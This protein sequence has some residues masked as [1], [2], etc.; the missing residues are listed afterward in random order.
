MIRVALPFGVGTPEEKRVNYRSALRG[1]GIE[2]VEEVSTLEGLD[3]LMLAGGI[4]VDPA[5]YGAERAPETEEPDTVRDALER[6]LI[7]QAL[8]RDLPIL[9]ICRGIQMFNVAL[10]GSL[11]QHVEGHRAP[12]QREAHPV[13]IEPGSV[14]ESILNRREFM[15]NS[16]HHQCVGTIAP[17]LAVTAKSPD[18]IVEALSGAGVEVLYDDR[19]ERAGVKFKDADLVGV[20]IRIAVGKKGLASG[21]AEWKLRASK[22]VE[23]VPLGGVAARTLE[24]IR[25]A[26]PA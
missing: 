3:G 16:R 11:I 24:A 19:D 26:R 10:G 15:V 7:V 14:L 25:A 18:G 13:S 21:Q 12:R 20:P 6:R 5:I 2:P 4:D 17:G 1:A 8:A 22:E 23:L 9:A